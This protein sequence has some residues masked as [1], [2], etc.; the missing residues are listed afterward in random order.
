[1]T[2]DPNVDIIFRSTKLEKELSERKRLVRGFG[3]RQADV[4]AQRLIQLRA[5]LSLATLSTLPQLRCHEL[6]ANREGQ[7]SV[8]LV[9]PYRLIFEPAHN[10]LPMK[11]DGGLDW[12]GVT[13]IRILGVVDTHG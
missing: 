2:A 1:M 5:A 10:P 7:I 12:S 9:H 11:D 3:K 8:D 4:I 6:K 13:V